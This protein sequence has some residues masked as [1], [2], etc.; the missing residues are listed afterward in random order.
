MYEVG[1]DRQTSDEVV[2][3][4]I[5]CWIF[6]VVLLAMVACSGGEEKASSE[7]SKAASKDRFLSDQTR[8]IEK[9]K[10]I[11]KMAQDRLDEINRNP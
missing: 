11:D 5:F 7:P 1:H 6:G 10:Q 2:M 3:K 9:A 8:A 4:K